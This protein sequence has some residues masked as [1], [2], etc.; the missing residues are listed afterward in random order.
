MCESAPAERVR[1]VGWTA[2][3]P[4]EGDL[5]DEIVGPPEIGAPLDHSVYCGSL[6]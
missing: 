1:R 3:A 6:P 2:R 5:G 4:G